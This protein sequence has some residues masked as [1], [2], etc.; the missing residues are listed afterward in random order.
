[1]YCNALGFIPAFANVVQNVWRKVCGVITFGNA[2]FCVFV[3]LYL[4]ALDFPTSGYP[5]SDFPISAYPL[6]DFPI[7][8]NPMPGAVAVRKWCTQ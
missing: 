1:M 8:D 6:L 3:S 7:P 5:V 4:I 2:T